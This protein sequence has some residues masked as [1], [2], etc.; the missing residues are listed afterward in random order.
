M[1][2]LPLSLYNALVPKDRTTRRL[3]ADI[4][5]GPDARHR[6]D[7]YAPRRLSAPLPAMVFVYGG[8]WDSGDRRDYEFAGRAL[9]SLGTVVVVADYRLTPG[10]N[11]PAFLDDGARAVEWVRRFSA[12]Y[13]GD[14]ERLVLAGHSAGAYNAVML[15]LSPAYRDISRASAVI[16]LSGP[17]DFL[18][19]DSPITRRTFG[20]VPDL[21]STQPVNFVT[22]ASPPMF[23]G[24]GAKD[25]TVYPRNTLALA[26]RLRTAG[27]AV[28]EVHY[29]GLGHAGTLM[30]LSRPLRGRAPVLADLERFLAGVSARPAGAAA[31]AA[32]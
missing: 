9:A 18:P 29:E 6:L 7:V 22:A 16:G 3:A 2:Y 25:G 1:R 32:G 21:A 26:G 27:V 4:A 20:A 5:F 19:L 15:A 31:A 11:Y 14:P 24:H 8:A 10:A 30:T 12:E 23:L 17:Y 13:G 28:T